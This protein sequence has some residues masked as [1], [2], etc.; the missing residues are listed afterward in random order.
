MGVIFNIDMPKACVEYDEETDER[1]NCPIYRSCKYRDTLNANRKPL[2]CPLYEMDNEIRV[3]DEVFADSNENHIRYLVVGIKFSKYKDCLLYSCVGSNGDCSSIYYRKSELKKTG[4]H[5]P[6]ISE[7]LEKMKELDRLDEI[8]KKK[9]E[10][11]ANVRS[12]G[13][14]ERT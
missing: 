14:N 4:R 6:Q 9:E 11:S 10:F 8:E 13:E 7:V 3:G 1:I 2:D 12:A 5:F